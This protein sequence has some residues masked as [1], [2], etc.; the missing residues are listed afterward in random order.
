MA[1][2]VGL[3]A[4]LPHTPL[5]WD[6]VRAPRR[7]PLEG[8]THCDVAVIGAGI[9]GL[10]T[11]L[12]VA[13]EGLSVCVV[14]RG[15]VASGTSGHTTG[16]VTSQHGLTYA[17][18]RARSREAAHIYAS[19]MEAARERVSSL[20]DGIDCDLTRAPALVYASEADERTE[21]EA[22]A[23]AARE[24]GLPMTVQ[25]QTELPFET[26]GALRLE[27]QNHL[28]PVRYLLDL[29]AKVEAHGGEIHTETVATGVDEETHGCRVHTD[30][31]VI[32]ARHVVVATLLP[33]LDRGL[34]FARTSPSRA[35]VV[36]ARVRG[37]LPDGMWQGASDRGFSLRRVRFDNEDLLMALGHSH[38]T[39]EAGDADHHTHVASY[40]AEHWPVEGFVHRWSAQDF[41]PDDGVPY[42]GAITPRS[43]RVHVV[44]GLRK[45]GLT[46]GTLAGMLITEALVG[47]AHP[48]SD[49]FS[50]RR[51]PRLSSAAA[52]ASG[53]TRV[54]LHF[55][56]DRL[57]DRGQRRL[58]ELAPGE[59][60]I[61]SCDGRKVAG[62]R[63]AD[64]TL[65]AVDARCTHL[66]CQVRWNALEDSWDCPCHGSR[67]A[68]DGSVLEGPATAPLADRSPDNLDKSV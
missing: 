7:G 1:D 31:G 58:E 53:N 4:Q 41:M 48:W 30:R 26:A 14:D 37:G 2:P 38:R 52:M 56:G 10:T 40:V 25:E 17:R 13:Q 9:T 64:G 6:G 63:S 61:V 27:G 36:T 29:A 67:F 18:L 62:H 55:V 50:A 39:G 33:F 8:D 44:T 19:S 15:E 42:I 5:W 28:H 24:A 57:R 22:E 47:R 12:L 66:G 16:K 20:A 54:A 60:A 68:P 32:R 3:V 59:G 43:R 21:L 35:H 51:P 45:W 46:G 65:R 49:F 34:H 23:R 11:A